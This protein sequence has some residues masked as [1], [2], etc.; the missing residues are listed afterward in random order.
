MRQN[1]PRDLPTTMPVPT[2]QTVTA[3]FS[4]LSPALK[5]KPFYYTDTRETNI[6]TEEHDVEVT[7][8]RSLPESELKG[9]TTDTSGFQWV[10]NESSLKGD[11]FFDDEIVKSR[12]YPEIDR[13]VSTSTPTLVRQL[14]PDVKILEGDSRC[15][16]H[17]DLRPHYSPRT[18]RQDPAGWRSRQANARPPRSRRPNPQGRC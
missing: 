13:C 5:E 7:D 9:Y 14:T 1:P 11:E 17:S 18:R 15:K 3:E 4:F 2:P 8:L 10:K 16:A 12:Y 6:I